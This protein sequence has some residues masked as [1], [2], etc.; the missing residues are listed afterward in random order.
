[1]AEN[2]DIVVTLKD[3]ASPKLKEIGDSMSNWDAYASS[4]IKLAAG[5]AAIGAAA[6]GVAAYSI[7]QAQEAVAGQKELA[8]VLESTGGA[9]GMTAESVNGLATELSRATNFTDDAVLSAENMLLTFTN[10]HA[11]VFPAATEATLNLATKFG[12]VEAASVQLGKALNDPVEGVNALR[13]VGVALTDEQQKQIEQFVKVGDVAS[14]QAVILDE[15]GTE[16]GGLAKSV[17]DPM[18]QAKNQ[19]NEMAE[20]LGMKLLPYVN[21]AAQA[22]LDWI[23][24]MGGIDGIMAT[25]QSAFEK[26]EPFLPIIIGAIG[27]GLVG[28]LT[29]AAGALWAFI[30]P[31]LIPM[32]IGAAIV[33]A[34]MLIYYAISHLGELVDAVKILIGMAWDWIYT[35]TVSVFTTISDFFTTVWNSIYDFLKSIWDAIT[36]AVDFALSFMLGLVITALEFLGIDWE[37]GWEAIKNI[38]SA[39]WEWM[40]NAFQIA[41]ASVKAVWEIG[42]GAIKGFVTPIW[43]SIKGIVSGAWDYIVGVFNTGGALIQTGWETIFNA[44]AGVCTSVFDAVKGTIVNA[45][46]YVID[47]INALIAMANSVSAKVSGP[48]LPTITPLAFSS[49]GVVPSINWG[50]QGSDTVPAMLTPGEQVLTKEQARMYNGGGSGITVIINNP[51]VMS[52]DDIVEKIGNPIM[53]VFKQHF[54]T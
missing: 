44:I 27:G 43:E 45:I 1:M 3:E 53:K 12:S 23:D 29:V 26:I 52:D 24:S 36:F 34:I 33:A 5:I 38:L 30:A 42:W 4:S 25:L 35:K 41:I 51:V 10:I 20:A 50:A 39:A 14:A 46:N 16:F 47:K 28:A 6:I 13:R 9:A 22:F 40:N 54:A 31:L 48:Q 2:L 49:G 7:G 21:Q 8:A 11:D 17:A 32:A 19:L 18:T 15:L 37:A